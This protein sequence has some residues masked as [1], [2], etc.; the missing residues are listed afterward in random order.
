MYL[1]LWILRGWFNSSILNHMK[2][3]E[4]RM[5]LKFVY[6]NGSEFDLEVVKF[7]TL[8]GDVKQ[9]VMHVDQLKDGKHLVIMSE[10]VMPMDENRKSKGKLKRIEI[11]RSS[12][13]Q[14]AP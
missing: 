4:P 9:V 3:P 7:T 5:W 2:T 10:A 13:G 11:L 8:R 1:G 6:D 12:D 14:T